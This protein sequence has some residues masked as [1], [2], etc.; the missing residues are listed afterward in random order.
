MIVISF[1]LVI[2]LGTLLLM[3]PVSTRLRVAT[4]FADCLFTA[5][6]ATCVTGLIIRDTYNYWS[7]FG[8]S[9]ILLLI[10]VGGLGLVTITLFVGNLLKRKFGLKALTLA[11]ETTSY[12]SRAGVGKIL[13]YVV[14]FSV[15]VEAVGAIILMFPFVKIYGNAGIFKAIF[16]SVSAYCNAGFDLMGSSGAFSN[17]ASLNGNPLVLITVMS[18]IVIGGLGVLVMLDCVKAV[19]SKILTL[20]S[21]VILTLTA[22]LIVG[23]AFL[24]LMS[25][26]YNP[27]TI[28]GMDAG[29]KVLNSFFASVTARTA[30]FSTV[31]NAA[32]YDRSKLLIIALMFIGAAPGSTGGGVKITTFWVVVMTIWSYLR[33]KKETVIGRSRVR[34]EVVYRA[35]TMMILMLA[36]IF[37]S[38]A[39]IYSNEVTVREISVLDTLYEVFSATCTVGLSADL[40]PT[41]LTSSRYILAAD[42]LLGRVGLVTFAFSLITRHVRGSDNEVLPEGSITV[43]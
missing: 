40:T 14:L 6:S 7:V 39:L 30:G 21:K 4:P 43:G 35:L 3:L 22:V 36:L 37:A 42:M 13:R 33:G 38:A 19:T 32:M 34:T 11:Q 2:L 8:Q 27:Q 25:E 5:T 28:G 17:L 24:F 10:Q 18:L 9:I 1:L 15:S 23:G 12:D 26:Y 20:H 31:S 41:L 16:I 29:G